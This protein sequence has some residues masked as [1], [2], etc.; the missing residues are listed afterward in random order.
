MT[1]MTD[2]SQ[3]TVERVTTRVT[4]EAAVR[5]LGGQL[6]GHS[7]QAFITY[8]GKPAP[9]GSSSIATDAS[10]ALAGAVAKWVR[11]HL[12]NATL[13]GDD[14]PMSATLERFGLRR[15]VFGR[16]PYTKGFTS[17][18]L[19]A[20]A[21]VIRRRALATSVPAC[22]VVSVRLREGEDAEAEATSVPQMVMPDEV[23]PAEFPQT[24][25]SS[26]SAPLLRHTPPH[27]RVG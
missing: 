2:T 3:A 22:R 17:P 25:R 11:E 16:D 24:P 8:E 27:Q 26:R 14:D 10:G 4:F 1:A 9:A 12:H 7:Y 6:T 15:Y 23:D 18:S 20:V 19:G 21:E 5:L 13:V